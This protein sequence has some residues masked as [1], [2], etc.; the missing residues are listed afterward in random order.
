MYIYMINQ[1]EYNSKYCIST[2]FVMYIFHVGHVG[3]LTYVT[4]ALD[5]T[6]L[7]S[8]DLFTNSEI[9]K[10]DIEISLFLSQVLLYVFCWL[11]AD[12][13]VRRY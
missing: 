5:S 4:N 10:C 9:K 8:D 11:N 13:G 12:F 7:L 6:L 2:K 1:S 3:L